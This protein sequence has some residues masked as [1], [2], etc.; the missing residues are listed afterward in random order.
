MGDTEL[1]K[2]GCEKVREKC[3]QACAKSSFNAKFN[4]ARTGV[5]TGMR[6]RV[7]TGMFFELV[8]TFRSVKGKPTGKPTSIFGAHGCVF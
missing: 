7:Q 4:K 2:Q 3:K 8:I 1:A 6:T 5:K